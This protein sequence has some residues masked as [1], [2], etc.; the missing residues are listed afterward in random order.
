LD[1]IDE[2]KRRV[3]IRVENGGHFVPESEIR[4]RYFEGFSNLNTFFSYFDSVDVFDCSAYKKV[5]S[6][7]FS[8]IHGKLILLKEFPV[9]LAPL[10]P[11]I[12][13]QVV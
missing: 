11:N 3:A 9:F 5:P 13:N 10:I 1:S 12:S 8:L 7:C 4:K 6:F 2:A